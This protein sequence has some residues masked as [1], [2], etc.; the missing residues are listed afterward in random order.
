MRRFSLLALLVLVS[1]PLYGKMTAPIE[2]KLSAD[3]SQVRPG[4]V[5]QIHGLVLP[6]VNAG[7]VAL[8]VETE[9][10]VVVESPPIELLYDIAAGMDAPFSL[11]VRYTG[12]GHAAV[13][14]RADAVD[15]AGDPLWGRRGSV[16]SLIRDG[17][18]LVSTSN[19]HVLERRV[20]EHEIR[21]G[22]LSGDQIEKKRRDLRRVDARVEARAPRFR[23]LTETEQQLN[24]IVGATSERPDDGRRVRADDA[25]DMIR[26]RGNVQ[27]TDEN[28]DRHPLFGAEVAIMDEDDDWDEHIVSVITDIDGNYSVL[29]DNDDDP[30]SDRDIYVE[31][32]AEN[33]LVDTQTEDDATWI[34]VSEVHDETPDGSVLDIS[35]V[36]GNSGNSSVFSVFQAATWIAG[37][38]QIVN[39]ESLDRVEVIWP[40]DEERTH[41]DSFSENINVT[42]GDRWDW[43]TVHHEYG[44]YVMDKFDAEDNP[45]G[46]HSIG[47]CISVTGDHGKD[48]GV[49]MAW[50]E[51]W[52]TFFAL[53][54]Q[55][56]MNLASLN[57]PRVGDD[58]Y[59]DLEDST[60]NYS[61]E[62]QN[63]QG[64]GEDNELAVQRA[65]WDLFDDNDDGRDTI[66]MSDRT[67]WTTI[68]NAEPIFFAAA[69]NALAAGRSA[70]TLMKMGAVAADH[71][72]GPSIS[73]P[74]EG[75]V[76]EGA[77]EPFSFRRNVGCSPH[78]DGDLLY[79]M[80]YDGASLD[81]ILTVPVAPG[82]FETAS[83]SLTDAMFETLAAAP[84]NSV[85]WSPSAYSL[86]A[87]MTGPYRGDSARIIINRPPVADAGADRTAECDS[88][89]KTGVSLSAGGS[90]DP[91]GDALTYQWSAPGVS[92][93][94]ANSPTPVGN[95]SIGTHTVTLEVS[96]GY[97]TDTDEVQV[98]VQDTTPPVISCPIDVQAECT[99][100]LGV[101]R[102]DPQLA[103]FFASVSATDTCDSTPVITHDAP[104]RLPV[105]VTPVTFTATDSHGNVSTCV[106]NITIVDTQLPTISVTLDRVVLWPPNHKFVTINAAVTVTDLCDPNPTFRLI[107][108]TSSDDS[109]RTKVSDDIAGAEFGTADTTFQL[110][111]ERIANGEPRRYTIVYR[112]LDS[113]MNWKDTTVYVDVPHDQRAK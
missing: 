5:V 69:W 19:P 2:V 46:Q 15:T 23:V 62:A 88:N 65:L 58:R 91:D 99:G 52:P 112:G 37:Y 110:R 87:P 36:A 64:E 76:I 101:D 16:Y 73:A 96:D 20:V 22:R 90:S 26:V 44:H 71:A 10:P 77:G 51:G 100:D 57:V 53:S 55:W 98:T 95:F 84:G 14:V 59:Q 74:L 81:L 34:M 24:R 82:S 35:F 9:G 39:G 113:S 67:M 11:T 28:G 108:I 43:D 47:D 33:N 25:S 8:S 63:S 45:G 75:A 85:I 6:K 60:L 3:E 42:F 27:W 31:V 4:G 48:E 18:G 38:A 92:F 93:D 89:G 104:E 103:A 17:R 32:R 54:G 80:F 66:S 94:D 86:P 111:A 40:C 1:V 107:S 7:L 21:T 97:S 78:F 30:F 49:R 61:I 12:S 79:A 72:I 50:A 83:F 109:V 29:V 70:T 105:G 41:Y 56:V 13:H 68:L 106:A 102:D